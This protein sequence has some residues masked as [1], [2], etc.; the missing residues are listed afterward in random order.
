ME[1]MKY[2]LMPAVTKALE[3]ES[4]R[5]HAVVSTEQKDR[6]GDII[7]AGGW[8]LSH[9]NAHPVLMSSHNYE[10][11]TNQI[12]EWEEM[13]V[14]GRRLEGVARYYVGEGNAE[15]DWGYKLAQKG[16]AAFSVGFIPDM[17]QAKVIED[18][19]YS[20]SF[21]FNGQELLEVSHVTVPANAEALQYVKQSG[22]LHPAITDMVDDAIELCSVDLEAITEPAADEVGPSLEELITLITSGFSDFKQEVREML[23]DLLVEGP[24]KPPKGYDAHYLRQIIHQ[25]FEEAVRK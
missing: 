17:A 9:F 19:G 16:R 14:R 11:L 24:K 21:E 6:D 10:K 8:N 22:L 18:A 2:K 13:K 23:A 20:Q 5:I 3:P 7:R 25:A 12:G 1:R 4:G 15:A